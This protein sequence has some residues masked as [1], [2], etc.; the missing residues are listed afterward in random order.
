MFNFQWFEEVKPEIPEE[1]QQQQLLWKHRGD[2]AYATGDFTRALE[3]YG[4][5][6]E[7]VAAGRSAGIRRDATEAMARCCLKLERLDDAEQWAIKLVS[8]SGVSKTL[9]AYMYM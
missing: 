5:C 2:L 6:L 8:N 1:T 4:S 7:T 9:Y 3:A